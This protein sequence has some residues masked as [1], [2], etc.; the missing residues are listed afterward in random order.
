V[1]ADLEKVLSALVPAGVKFIVI[2]GWAAG[3]HGSARSTL[4]VD[5]DLVFDERTVRMGLNFTL[6]TS[7]GSLDL[8]GEVAGGGTMRPCSNATW[9]SRASD[10]VSA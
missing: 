3:L 9:R 8:L 6:S 7:L 1:A 4:D 2:G 10:T 5:V